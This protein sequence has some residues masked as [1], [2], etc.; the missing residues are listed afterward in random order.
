MGAKIGH[1]KGLASL[2]TQ[3]PSNNTEKHRSDVYAV[4]TSSSSGTNLGCK[5]NLRRWQMGGGHPVVNKASNTADVFVN[6]IQFLS[7]I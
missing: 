3:C 4:H 7:D 6:W 2:K 1:R 5:S